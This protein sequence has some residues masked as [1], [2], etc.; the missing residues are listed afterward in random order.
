MTKRAFAAQSVVVRVAN[1][2]CVNPN[3]DLPS[4][5]WCNFDRFDGYM[6]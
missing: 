1:T 6:E 5:G 4:L 2:R 3:A